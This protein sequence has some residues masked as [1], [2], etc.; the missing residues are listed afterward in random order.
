M[1]KQSD[2]VSADQFVCGRQENVFCCGQECEYMS[3]VG[4]RS[5]TTGE[6]LPTFLQGVASVSSETS[7]FSK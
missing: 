6:D 2:F 3:V 1:G 4:H 5:A 7:V